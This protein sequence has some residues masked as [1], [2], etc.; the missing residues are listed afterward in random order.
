MRSRGLLSRLPEDVIASLLEGAQRITYPPGATGLVWQGTAQAAIVLQGT[1]RQFIALSDGGQV[2][3]RY[4]KAGDLTGIFAPRSPHLSRAVIALET[5]ELVLIDGE[6]V[7]RTALAHPALAWEMV[8]EMTTVL[9]LNQKALLVRSQGTVRQ[10]V[11]NA[12][13]ELADLAGGLTPGRVVHGTQQELAHAA[14]TVRE[15][16]TAVLQDLK[17]DGMVEVQ[18]SRVVIRDAERIARETIGLGLA[19]VELLRLSLSS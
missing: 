9:N 12:I 3:T 7:R 14:G 5:A 18:R 1:L 8:E 11:V 15:V 19:V 17:R 10:R 13:A 16:V 6:R 4:L 2:T